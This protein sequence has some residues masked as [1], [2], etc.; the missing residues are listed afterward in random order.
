MLQVILGVL[1]HL[2]TAGGGALATNG[3]IGSSDVE[4]G[5]GAVLTL[6][7]LVWS[8]WQKLNSK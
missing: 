7:G 3:L 2:L 6:V 4:L 8:V 5:V 1:R